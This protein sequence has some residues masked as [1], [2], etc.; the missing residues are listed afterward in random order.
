MGLASSAIPG[1]LICLF[2]IQASAQVDSLE[3]E[4]WLAQFNAQHANRQYP[5]ALQAV[6]KALVAF[7]TSDNLSRWLYTAGSKAY[8]LL[9]MHD[10]PFSALEYLDSCL[11]AL[12][13]WR[14]PAGASE[15]SE[16]CSLFLIQAYIAKQHTED[17]VLVKSALQNAYAIYAKSPTGVDANLAGYLYFQLGNAYVRLGE[18]ESARQIFKEAYAYS[19]RYQMP[20]VAK[21]NDYAGLYVAMKNYP[22]AKRYFLEGLATPNLSEEDRLF[23]Q[24][25]YAECLAKMQDFDEALRINRAVEQ[26]LQQPLDASFAHKL[27]EFQYNLF[28]NYG[29][30]Y[31]A[32]KDFENAL[33]WYRRALDTAQHYEDATQRQIAFFYTEI[34]HILLAYGKPAEALEAYHRALQAIL[35]GFQAPV[36]QHPDAASFTAENIIYKALE[37]KALS[38]EQLGR[39]DKALDCY[40]LIP[41]VEAKLRATHDYESSTQQA[42]EGSRLRLDKAVALAWQL[43]EQQHD[44]RLGERAFHLTEQVRGVIL[45]QNLIKSKQ[46]TQLPDSLRLQQDEIQVK[47]AWYER[48]IAAEKRKPL[49]AQRVAQLEDDLFQWKRKLEATQ[50]DQ[51]GYARLDAAI[52]YLQA[53][54]VPGLLRSDGLLVDYYLTDSA[55]FVFSFS[56]ERFLGWRQATLTPEWKQTARQFGQ[57]LTRLNNDPSRKRWFLDTAEALYR[58]LLAPEL[59]GKPNIG[60]LVIIPDNLLAYIPFEVLLPQKI[61]D[62][63][64]AK[65]PYL[66]HRYSIAYSYSATLLPIQR[67]ISHERQGRPFFAAF[68]PVYPPNSA[69]PVSGFSLQNLTGIQT[70]SGAIAGQLG[71]DCYAREATETLFK[72]VASKYVVLLLGMHG[73]ADLDNQALS[74]LMI[75]HPQA[76]QPEDNVLYSGE[77]QIMQLQAELVVLLA[78][79]TGFGKWQQGEGIYSLARAFTMAGVPATIMSLWSLPDMS[80]PPLVQVLF[81][82]LAEKNTTIDQ[83]LQE[84]KRAYLNNEEHFE[85]A[86]PFFWAGLMAVGDMRPINMPEK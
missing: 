5:E 83:A 7:R 30:I 68:T 41:L 3:G 37:G 23:T 4:K 36:E 12:P 66:L 9:D 21:F 40:E 48:E 51:P 67:S 13:A 81:E 86:H 28:E 42:L 43:Y 17:F 56:A 72:Q 58:L 20:E 65:L 38:F 15:E 26:T 47:I 49:D 1:I 75:G 73:F 34:G 45:M 82:K 10:Q 2:S 8:L 64:W 53:G 78:C 14:L 80:A 60:S 59:E 16:Y 29:Q 24:L 57:F 85:L 35:P 69:D 50:Q 70:V 19:K 22:E 18:F 31:F 61:K 71:G 44:E 6:D 32:K 76:P 84:A 25:G 33:L 55:L 46:K 79:H 62:A 74:R 52:S 54:E 77:L 27:P 39:I 11:T 63:P